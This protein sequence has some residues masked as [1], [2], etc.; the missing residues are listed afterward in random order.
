MSG[1]YEVT[2]VVRPDVSRADITKIEEDLTAS[3]TENKATVK[4]N[5]YWGL[6]TLAYRINKTNKGHYSFM[7]V[8]AGSEA[9][10]EM[11]RLLRI[12][13]NVVRHLI[14]RVE[15]LEEEP[16]APLRESSRDAA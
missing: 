2:F 14:I 16:S 9:I 10:H 15:A 12:N 6:R 8:E 1:L 5:E 7:G 4:K 3:L 13:E 11:D